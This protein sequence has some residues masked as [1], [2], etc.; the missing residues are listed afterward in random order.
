M[1]YFNEHRE[2]EKGLPVES[3]TEGFHLEAS[4]QIIRLLQSTGNLPHLEELE[5][6]CFLHR[7]FL[8]GKSWW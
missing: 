6:I 5:H 1:R 2:H 4:R 8:G 7:L 3:E